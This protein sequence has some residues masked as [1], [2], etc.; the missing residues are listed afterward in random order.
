VSRQ[1]QADAVALERE[2]GARTHAVFDVVKRITDV[3]FATLGL[4][5]LSPLILAVAIGVGVTLGR[6]ILFRQERVGRH[7]RRFMLTKF[8]T[9]S[10]SE[11]HCC[12]EPKA[13]MGMQAV[14]DIVVGRF[15]HFLRKTGLDELPQLATVLSGQMSLIG[16]RPLLVRYMGRY[17][18][19]QA[20]R[21]EVRPGITGWAQ[22]NGRT[23]LS[24]EERLALDGFYVENRSLSLDAKVAWRSVAAVVR[25]K[26]FRKEG[27]GTGP[28]FLGGGTP[29]GLCPVTSLSVFPATGSASS[30]RARNHQEGAAGS[31]S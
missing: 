19:E 28:E 20:R 2:T 9:L 7:G 6:P 25:G 14:S 8:R 29:P 15:A 11:R 21:H 24:W 27:T 5:V 16:P 22:V 23:D 18:R 10:I 30:Q 17:T 12:G 3:V 1:A 26:G 13:C 4:I 31:S